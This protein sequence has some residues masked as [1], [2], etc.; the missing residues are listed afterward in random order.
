VVLVVIR[1]EVTLTQ[2]HLLVNTLQVMVLEV[3]VLE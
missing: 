1:V 2:G 3:V